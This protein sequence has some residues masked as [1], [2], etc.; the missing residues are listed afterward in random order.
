MKNV[1]WLPAALLL[2]LALGCTNPVQSN[3]ATAGMGTIKV[4][5]PQA[6]E[7]GLVDISYATANS[8]FYQLF[9]Y[10]VNNISSLGSLSAAGGS[11]VVAPDTYTVIVLAGTSINSGTS[12]ELLGCGEAKSVVV[13]A[14][15]TT[16]VAITL[17]NST[18][19]LTAPSSVVIGTQYTMT[20]AGNTGCSDV[21][22]TGGAGFYQGSTAI[23]PTASSQLSVQD[24]NYS[25]SPTAPSSAGTLS[26]AWQGFYIGFVNLPFSGS[27]GIGNPQSATGTHWITPESNSP[28]TATKN[29]CTIPINFANPPPTRIGVTIGWGSGQ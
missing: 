24:W 25:V 11:L 27:G 21:C 29:Y 14:N 3:Q 22:V 16:T 23:G 6:S 1:F 4:T 28:V 5:F 20:A 15:H 7:K 18:F 13:T 19:A 10:G 17:C 12:A 2:A 8:N 26:F 9:A